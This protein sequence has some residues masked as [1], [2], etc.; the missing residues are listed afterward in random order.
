LI[1]F[2]GRHR[3][4][5]VSLAAILCVSLL[6]P[7]ALAATPDPAPTLQATE[8]Q[9]TALPADLGRPTGVTVD[10][11]TGDVTVAGE[12]GI[13]ELRSRLDQ[14]IRS[15]PL[16]T[17]L[18]VV[19]IAGRERLLTHDGANLLIVEETGRKVE[20]HFDFEEE[21]SLSV[22]AIDGSIVALLRGRNKVEIIAPDGSVE[23]RR[24]PITP[25]NS[26]PAAHPGS[27][28]VYVVGPS[29]VS[30]VGP[31]GT[32][33]TRYEL[34]SLGSGAPVAANFGP[35]ADPTDDPDELSLYVVVESSRRHGSGPDP[36]QSPAADGE[37]TYLF[38][39][40]TLVQ[41]LPAASVVSATLI[42]TTDLSVLDPPSPDPAGIAYVSSRNRLLI[43]D[44]E[45]DEMDIY[46]GFNL[47]EVGLTGELVDT[48]TTAGWSNE[49]TG[50]S[51][52]PTSG[53]LFVSDDIDQGR[54][55]VIDPGPDDRYGTN[56]DAVSSVDLGTFTE[57]IDSEGVAYDPATAT[58]F[59]ADG[60]A[61]EVWQISPGPNGVFE[62]GGA[63]GDDTA[64]HFDME[65]KGARDPEGIAIDPNT[66]H[67]LVLDRYHEVV[68]EVTKSGSLVRTLDLDAADP[69]S[70]AGVVLAPA[71]NGSGTHMYVVERGV[72][73]GANPNENDGKVYEMAAGFGPLPAPGAPWATNDAAATKEDAPV[74]V[75]VLANDT[76]PDDDPLTITNL[77]QPSDGTATVNPNKTITYTPDPGFYGTDTFTYRAFDG[78]INSNRAKVSIKVSPINEPPSANDDADSTN[79]DTSVLID[80]LANDGDP[81]DDPLTVTGLT[82]PANG[83]ATVNAD[84]TVTYSPATDFNGTDTFTYRAADGLADSNEATVTLTVRPVEDPLFVDDDGSTFEADIEWI[85]AE[86]ITKG[87]NPPVNDRY[88]PDDFVTR[89]QMAAFLHRA[90]DDVLS[91]TEQVEFIDDNGNTFEADIEWLGGTGVTKGCN[92]PDNDQYC[93]DDFV[94]RGQMAAF[95][96]RGLGYTDD[97]GGDLFIDDDGNTFEADID[98]LGTAGVTK[99]CNPPTNDQYCPNDFVTRGQMAAFLRRALEG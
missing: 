76:D 71:S 6:T 88:C 86:G 97:G 33:E 67:L 53:R 12:D 68:Y 39:E 47:F 72:D 23:T 99:G 89:G 46:E 73:N 43:G 14:T 18:P 82:Q 61:K 19:G 79:E 11:E 40:V 57:D 98:K 42:R 34:M 91:P 2:G 48:G 32:L 60:T 29:A 70:P 27:D 37:A 8:E 78:T 38:H 95:L 56:D 81:D 93:P 96:V 17:D 87:C 75:D 90:L 4:I 10:F 55:N 85:A 22:D 13:L 31:G 15:T 58:L 64:T 25:S 36:R 84:Q 54:I 94:T 63:A 65:N 44:S 20:T 41:P 77:T 74:S 1:R 35:S 16:W 52:D 45:V 69:K 3:S 92:P 9:T 62:G 83:T 26:V 80:V 59:V 49:P 30:V 66:N 24:L 50:A 28:D 5:G 21:T 7:A 51:H